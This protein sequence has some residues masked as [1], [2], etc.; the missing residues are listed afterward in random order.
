MGMQWVRGLLHMEGQERRPNQV[1]PIILA[2]LIVLIVS[3]RLNI[4]ANNDVF[5][6][7]LATDGVLKK[8]GY[9]FFT[10]D[11]SFYSI[12]SR[13]EITRWPPGMTVLA[14]AIQLVAK[15]PLV[16]LAYLQPLL[17]GTSFLFLW[18]ALLND[19]GSDYLS[20]SLAVAAS[21]TTTVYFYW[22]TEVA[23]EPWFFLALSVILWQ[24]ANMEGQSAWRLIPAVWVAEIF[25]TAGAYIAGGLAVVLFLRSGKNS[26]LRTIV[27]VTVWFFASIAP[28]ALFHAY[29]GFRENTA[30]I[31]WG[32]F[33]RQILKQFYWQHE[34]LL[35][36]TEWMRKRELLGIVFSGVI[37]ALAFGALMRKRSAWPRSALLWPA[38]AILGICYCLGLSLTAALAGYDWGNVYRVCGVGVILLS[39]AWWSVMSAIFGLGRLRRAWILASVVIIVAKSGWYFSRTSSSRGNFDYR[40]AVVAF[41]RFAEES[42]RDVVVLCA[43]TGTDVKFSRAILYAAKTWWSSPV[44]LRSERFSGGFTYSDCARYE[45]GNGKWKWIER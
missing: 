18:S 14:S 31:D 37:A 43:E 35:P 9:G 26:M 20:S 17:A 23:S 1:L 36:Y 21:L 34:I 4:S 19:F 22:H 10:E 44:R 8:Y 45:S 16:V 32:F 6:Q 12:G 28:L 11:G 40:S 42:D 25:R 39:V 13:A 38:C 30:G 29:Y 41:E 15:D 33:W 27:K 5:L 24:L 7:L 2:V 3:L